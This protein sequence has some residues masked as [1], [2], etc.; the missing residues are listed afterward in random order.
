V[1]SVTATQAD[2][3]GHLTAHACGRARPHASV[4]NYADSS[5]NVT[6]LAWTELSASGSL[7]VY[8][9]SATHVVV[10]LV[11]VVHRGAG[12]EPVTA[13]RLADSRA[14]QPTIDG[15]RQGF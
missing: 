7:C 4:L 2:T 1:V 5:T 9:L 11:A 13:V 6:N 8:S 12:V 10:D 15:R 3:A 14:G